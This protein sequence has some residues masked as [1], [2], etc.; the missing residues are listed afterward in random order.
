[1]RILKLTSDVE[2]E[3][4]AARRER[5]VEAEH[6]GSKIVVE[7]RLGGDAALFEF[8]RQFDNSAFGEKNLRIGKAEMRASRKRVSA[9]FVRAIRQASRNIRAVAKRQLPKPW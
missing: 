6:I 7:V 4:L 9:D 3:L 1:M 5:D 8:V 2:K